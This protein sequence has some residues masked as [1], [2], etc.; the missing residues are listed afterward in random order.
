M[1]EHPIFVH[2]C[3]SCGR[4]AP[5]DACL[6][7][8]ASC[9]GR[10]DRFQRVL[11]LPDSPESDGALSLQSLRAALAEVA[12]GD[13]LAAAAAVLSERGPDAWVADACPAFASQL[14]ALGVPPRVQRALV[15]NGFDSFERVCSAAASMSEAAVWA[16]QLG[17]PPAAEVLLRRLRHAAADL[18]GCPA[19]QEQKRRQAEEADED[20][21]AM[22]DVPPDLAE[23][24]AVGL[25]K[26]ARRLSGH[27]AAEAMEDEVDEEP[28]DL[29]D[30]V[31]DDS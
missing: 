31:S 13:D 5:E 15:S 18:R 26:R 23:V 16:E 17:L 11:E 19:G 8:C 25:T 22:S 6:D 2:W 7:A 3:A 30:A 9:R 1:L 27:Q 24:Y 14:T 21:L 10:I 28:G 29:Q 4:E 20:D 12:S